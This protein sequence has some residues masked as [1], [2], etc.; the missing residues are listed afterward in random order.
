MFPAPH[1][2]EPM[3]RQSSC[4]APIEI[5]RARPAGTQPAWISLAKSWPD[6]SE[7]N[8][9]GGA[10]APS[11][12]TA[13]P[14]ALNSRPPS[15]NEPKLSVTPTIPCPP[16]AAHSAVIR[17]IAFRLASYMASV[18]GPYEPQPPCPD[19]CVAAVTT[20]PKTPLDQPPG[21]P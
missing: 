12:R 3:V 11:P 1:L 19:T 2:V 15:G 18:S 6:R 7:L 5:P 14:I 13:V 10:G 9:C 8:G 20:P 4:L 17:P 21:Q 16:S